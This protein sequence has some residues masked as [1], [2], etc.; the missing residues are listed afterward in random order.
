MMTKEQIDAK[1]KEIIKTWAGGG[2]FAHNIVR[3]ELQNIAKHDRERADSIYI[4]LQ[5]MGY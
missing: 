1:E 4:K 3:L 5:R 2:P